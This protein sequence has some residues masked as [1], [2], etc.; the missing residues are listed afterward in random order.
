MERSENIELSGLLP[1]CDWVYFATTAKAS[2]SVTA[3]FVE[4]HQI[5]VRSVY[6]ADGQRIANVQHLEPGQ[7][8]L[9]VHGGPGLP[10]RALFSCT[11]AAAASPIRT[12]RHHFDAFL[13][14]PESLASLLRADGYE[15]DPVLGEFTG[16]AMTAVR[17]LRGC[18]E[19]IP[20]PPGCPNAIWRWGKVFAVAA[21]A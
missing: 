17:D 19:A 21:L 14:I 12:S 7:Q 4:D 11:I 10:Y 15:S 20:R 1:R 9:L 5:I 16:I 8:M 13:F 3:G 6:N 2:G 18:T